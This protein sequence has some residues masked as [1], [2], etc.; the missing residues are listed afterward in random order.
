VATLL[1]ITIIPS[2]DFTGGLYAYMLIGLT[3][4]T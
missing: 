4:K 3:S 1:S 2:I